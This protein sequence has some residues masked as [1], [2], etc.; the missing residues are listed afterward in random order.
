MYDIIGKV[1][2]KSL[3]NNGISDENVVSKFCNFSVER[4]LILKIYIKTTA[5]LFE[6][7]RRGQ[8]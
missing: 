3:P 8:E 4:L 2:E 5:V 1:K 6:T 7:R